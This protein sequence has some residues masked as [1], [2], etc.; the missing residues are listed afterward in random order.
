M[1]PKA[2]EWYQQMKT[3]SGSDD[4]MIEEMNPIMQLPTIPSVSMF[5]LATYLSLQVVFI[6]ECIL[7]WW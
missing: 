6:I 4:R 3:I 2:V 5:Q 1:A 7:W